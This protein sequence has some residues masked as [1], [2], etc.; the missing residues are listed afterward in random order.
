MTDEY[1][2]LRLHPLTDTEA[3]QAKLQ[4][5]ANDGFDLVGV[6]PSTDSAL[7]IM[8]QPRRLS[9]DEATAQ[10]LQQLKPFT[11]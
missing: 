8:K 2:V 10:E 1:L 7:I 3:A 6:I 5:A 9:P 11:N 4:E